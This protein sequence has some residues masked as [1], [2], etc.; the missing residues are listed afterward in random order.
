MSDLLDT[1]AAEGSAP[2]AHAHLAASGASR[3]A[4]SLETIR[5]LLLP[6]VK[7]GL[8]P[9][10][11]VDLDLDLLRDFERELDLDRVADDAA[12]ADPAKTGSEDTTNTK[13]GLR[14]LG[15]SRTVHVARLLGGSRPELG[16][17]A[18]VLL[19]GLMDCLDFAWKAGGN[20]KARRSWRDVRS[21]LYS[22]R[23]D[24]PYA[25][26]TCCDLL[27]LP[28]AAIRDLVGELLPPGIENV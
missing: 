2:P 24:V 27:D 12:A 25:F 13:K 1:T 4:D 19:R 15:P 17:V 14:R 3:R 21:W 8:Q 10:P 11:L 16:L 18:A 23:V 6:F 5:R 26:C 20:A 22:D 7:P 28:A 9:N